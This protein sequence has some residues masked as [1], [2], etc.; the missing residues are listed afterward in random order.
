LDKI[1]LYAICTCAG[2]TI[3]SLSHEMTVSHHLATPPDASP[4]GT[5]LRDVRDF[6]ERNARVCAE[7]LVE[8]QRLVRIGQDGPVLVQFV[9]RARHMLHEMEELL[10]AIGPAQDAA[11]FARIA[12]LQRTLTSVQTAMQVSKQD[13]H[14][15]PPAAIGNS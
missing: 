7:M 5:G 12:A 13:R 9:H 6:L 10:P 14:L 8:V 2:V 4:M 3:L 1:A 15:G 11:L